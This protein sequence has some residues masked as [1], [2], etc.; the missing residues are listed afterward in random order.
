MELVE[1]IE[2]CLT[3][4]ERYAEDIEYKSHKE[5]STNDVEYE[6]KRKAE[7][8]GGVKLSYIEALTC[9]STIKR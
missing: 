7:Q 8:K 5:R 1:P 6:S 9:L 4:M 2:L 3:E